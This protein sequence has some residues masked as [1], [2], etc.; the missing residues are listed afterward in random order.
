MQGNK[1]EI[2]ESY[3]RKSENTKTI[4]EKME[5]REREYRNN[6]KILKYSRVKQ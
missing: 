3:C 4:S 5:K 2:N 6:M 1:K